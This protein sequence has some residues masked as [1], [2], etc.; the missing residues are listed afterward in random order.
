M[1]TRR[2]AAWPAAVLTSRAPCTRGPQRRT[3]VRLVWRTSCLR[4]L[5]SACARAAIG[6]PR[7]PV[8]RTRTASRRDRVNLIVARPRLRRT[9]FDRSARNG[10]SLPPSLLREILMYLAPSTT[11]RRHWKVI[12]RLID[13]R[14][15]ALMQPAAN[16]GLAGGGGG[17]RGGGVVPG[18]VPVSVTIGAGPSPSLV[19]TILELRVPPVGAFGANRTVTVHPPPGSIAAGQL[20]VVVKSAALPVVGVSE[21]R[22]SRSAPTFV[23][24][25]P[26]EP[27]STPP[28]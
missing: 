17:G 10:V 12:T 4:E 14:V 11:D 9:V 16:L 25:R 21:L 18:V 15:T 22:C 1:P 2:P 3:R 5:L 23:T 13:I 7:R 6:S 24:R 19:T 26:A 28:R 8:R 20:C 27:K